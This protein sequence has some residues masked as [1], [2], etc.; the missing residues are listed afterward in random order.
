MQH[1]TLNPGPVV[2]RGIRSILGVAVD[3]GGRGAS[4]WA[5]PAVYEDPFPNAS[6]WEVNGEFGGV[7]QDPS[8]VASGRGDIDVASL[9]DSQMLSDDGSESWEFWDADEWPVFSVA[10]PAL[11]CSTF[12]LA[13]L[14]PDDVVAEALRRHEQTLWPKIERQVWVGSQP[15]AF[16]GTSTTV[17]DTDA[18]P[19]A[20]GM[21]LLEA[22]WNSRHPEHR[23]I[24]WLPAGVS[25][26][27]DD[28]GV[29]LDARGL[30]PEGNAVVFLPGVPITDAVGP[31]GQPVLHQ[32]GGCWEFWGYMTGRLQLRFGPV[33]FDGG[34]GGALLSLDH[35]TNDME[36]A[37]RQNVGFAFFGGAT[38]VRFAADDATSCPDPE[39]EPEPDP[40]P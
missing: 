35:M 7:F 14:D 6:R 29:R 8:T 28:A 24:I 27:L 25:H 34:P 10:G 15:Q 22:D 40:E 32:G 13:G 20:L 1:I 11:K 37:A 31:A 4:R 21:S 17:L 5:Q 9:C 18:H 12:T 33:T 39:P 23:G 3:V 16:T 36:V 26:L 19:V 38:A 30:T 2:S